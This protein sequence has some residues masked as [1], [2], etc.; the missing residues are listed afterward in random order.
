MMEEVD[1]MPFNLQTLNTPS[2]IENM[3]NRENMRCYSYFKD[4]GGLNKKEIQ[5]NLCNIF[6]FVI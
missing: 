1:E 6:Y 4:H 3:L 2:L 5:L